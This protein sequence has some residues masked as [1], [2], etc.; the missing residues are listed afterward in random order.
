MGEHG[1]WWGGQPWKGGTKSVVF[2]GGIPVVQM[3]QP[4]R[5][6]GSNEDGES[7]QAFQEIMPE[8]LGA[9]IDGGWSQQDTNHTLLLV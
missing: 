7:P 6:R 8:V 3:Q 2:G 4:S 9:S 1:Q 5:Q